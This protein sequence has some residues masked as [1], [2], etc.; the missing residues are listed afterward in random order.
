M[1]GNYFAQKDKTISS[2]VLRVRI[3]KRW[4]FT[5]YNTV[6]LLS[7]SI[8]LSLSLFCPVSVKATPFIIEY[9]V[10]KQHTIDHFSIFIVLF[11]LRSPWESVCTQHTIH[12]LISF[13]VWFFFS[14][15]PLPFLCFVLSRFL[16]LDVYTTLCVNHRI[17]NLVLDQIDTKFQREYPRISENIRKI[18]SLHLILI[19]GYAQTDRQT[20]WQ[21]KSTCENWHIH[22]FGVKSF[23]RNAD[24]NVVITVSRRRHYNGLYHFAQSFFIACFV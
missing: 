21:G 12:M 16:S 15:S 1:N 3:K 23:D 20:G 8:S 19:Q 6:D 7:H 11:C 13:G 10:Q 17:I 5:Q 14:L 2:S 4:A 9:L 18:D 24:K 22:S